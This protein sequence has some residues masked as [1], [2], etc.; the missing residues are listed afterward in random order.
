M[1][2]GRT[3]KKYK[4]RKSR[5]ISSVKKYGIKTS[6]SA[7]INHLRKDHGLQPIFNS[8]CGQSDTNVHAFNDENEFDN[9]P[10]SSTSSVNDVDY[11]VPKKQSKLDQ[12]CHKAETLMPASNGFEANRNLAVLLAL[13]LKPFSSIESMGF[14]YLFKKN[15]C[16]VKLLSESTLRKE[17]ITDVYGMVK[18]KIGRELKN[19]LYLSVM[20][21]GWSDRKGRPFVGLRAGFLDENYDYKV[22]T[23]SCKVIDHH[24]AKNLS[25]YI[26]DELK[27]FGR[28][29]AKIFL[30][31]DGA[32]NMLKTGK[33]LKVEHHC[34]CLAHCIHLLLMTDGM[35]NN[36]EVEDLLTRCNNVITTLHWKGSALQEECKKILDREVIEQLISSIAKIMDE[37]ELDEENPITENTDEDDKKTD[38]HVHKHRT[39]KVSMPTRW[40]S[41][42]TMISSLLDLKVA[43]DETMK[44]TGNNNNKLTTKTTITITMRG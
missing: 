22:V 9:Q 2:F 3:E 10:N 14:K 29:G 8:A 31:T 11:S 39:L 23:L 1:P 38:E 20:I 16:N 13:D 40:N 5:H 42:L 17:C 37:C 33:T 41:T 30:T 18:E 27:S 19:A 15:V 12:F 44:C 25:Q 34:H 28:S 7:L 6:T 43:V 32:A 24:I 26:I 35:K 4:D 21:D 36:D